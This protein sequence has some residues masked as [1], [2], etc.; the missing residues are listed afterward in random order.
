MEVENYWKSHGSQLPSSVNELRGGARTSP[1][2][3]ITH[4]PYEYQAGAGSSY[5]LC[6][7][8]ARAS[9]GDPATSASDAWNHT[10]GHFC[11]QLDAGTTTQYPTQLVY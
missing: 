11:F 7:V 6:A 2:D 3:P 1:T 8:F 9:Q 10:A 4:A 5:Q